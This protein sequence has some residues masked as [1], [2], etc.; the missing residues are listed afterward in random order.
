[1]T[2]PALRVIGTSATLTPEICRRA[3]DDL[4]F[5]ITFEV[6]D[7]V[8]CLRRGVMAPGSFDIYDQW[9]HSVDLLWTAGSIRSIDTA[10]IRRWSELVPAGSMEVARSG[11]GTPPGN[12]L[13]VQADGTLGAAASGEG[14]P[15]ISMLPTVYNADAFV[16]TPEV[17]QHY[18]QTRRESWAWLL[19]DAWHGRCLLSADPAGSAVELAIA[20][21]AADVLSAQDPG[22]LM[23]EEIDELFAFLM[24]RR[25]TGHFGHFWATTEESLRGMSNPALAIGSLWSPGYYLLRGQQKAL[26][27]ADPAEGSRGWHAGNCISSAVEGETLDMAYAYLNWW[28]DGVPGAIMARRGY[29]ISVPGP[30]RDTLSSDEWAYWYA[31]EPAGRDLP[32]A[33]G[34]TVVFEGEQRAGG[35]YSER[36]ARIAVWST[37]MP[38]NNYL[39]RRWR[40]FIAP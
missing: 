35:S 37:I 32:G 30:L 34:L 21:G 15:R 38:E 11:P 27:Y 4:G 31:G 28:L 19:D 6:L 14:P 40:E 12:V 39:I 5:A 22:N 13:F 23:I 25:R 2:A 24:A 29:Y 9:I 26:I 17:A 18:G 1:M 33:D 8:D 10:R 20:A 3:R 16:Y 36:M 7:G